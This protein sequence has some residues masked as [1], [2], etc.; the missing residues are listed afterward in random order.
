MKNIAANCRY[1]MKI[2]LVYTND[3]E[4]GNKKIEAYD[5]WTD[6]TKQDAWFTA[7]SIRNSRS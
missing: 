7:C 4:N 5:H 3:Q 2:L 1:K 6:D